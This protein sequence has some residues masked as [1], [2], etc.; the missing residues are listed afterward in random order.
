MPHQVFTLL[1]SA[2]GIHPE[3]HWNLFDIRTELEKAGHHMA[4][5]SV[6]RMP[7]DLARNELATVALH[8]SC[9]VFLLIDDDVQVKPYWLPKMLDALDAGA[10]IISAPC[11]LRDHEH[12][13]A[14]AAVM[15]NVIPEEGPFVL[16]ELRTYT[17]SR[18]GL[19]AVLVKRKVLEVLHESSKEKYA[20]RMRPGKLSAPIFRSEIVQAKK[21]V[22][23]APEDLYVYVLDDFA[24]SQ[25]AIEAGF[26]IH[27]AIDVPTV[28]D[29]MQGCFSQELDR[30]RKAQEQKAR[31][32]IV[33]PDGK[34]VR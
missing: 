22:A 34:A 27:A 32:P 18:T 29:G 30:L 3:T 15:F 7:L 5:A 25:K 2:R 9:D 20:S 12:G 23:D 33:G 26:K 16:G 14:Q 11:R 6:Y 28:H 17:C 24:F 13:G 31:R 21:M 10:D 4:G 8:T 1:P 19:G